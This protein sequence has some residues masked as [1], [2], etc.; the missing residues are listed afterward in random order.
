MHTLIIGARHTGKST[1]IRRIVSTLG[2]TVSGFETKKED[3][4]EDPSRGTPVYIYEVGKPHQ[5]TPDNLLG[6]CRD[7]H[8]EA[9][10]HAFDRFAHLISEEETVSDLIVMDEIGFMESSSALFCS[11]ILHRL[12]GDRPVLAAVKCNDT[13]FLNAVRSH[14]NC[15]CFF[16]TEENREK[17]SPSV[18]DFVRLQLG[19]GES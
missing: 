9:A 10:E 1:L 2:C 11:E 13:P 16:I 18:L 5:Q 6:Y 8:P 12:D 4:M 17:L 14:P 3:G 15:R 19:H 7:R